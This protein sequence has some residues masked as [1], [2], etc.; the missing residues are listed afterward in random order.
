[1]KNI[2]KQ[3]ALVLSLVLMISLVSVT[4]ATAQNT[5]TLSHDGFTLDF[6]V[7]SSSRDSYTARLRITNNTGQGLYQWVLNLNRDMGLRSNDTVSG[8]RL[9][10]QQDGVTTISYDNWTTYIAAIPPRGS[11]TL[12]FNNA[13]TVDG[14]VPIPTD[15]RINQATKQ[16]LPEQYFSYSLSGSTW[17]NGFSHSLVID[18]KTGD[19][20]IGWEL[21]FDISGGA[22]ATV[23]NGVLLPSSTT[24][25]A[26]IVHPRYNPVLHPGSTTL[27]IGGSGDGSAISISNVR[28]FHMVAEPYLN[29]LAD[30]PPIDEPI[31]EPGDEPCDELCDEP[32]DEPEDELCCDEYPYCDDTDLPPV[33][34]PWVPQDPTLTI[35]SNGLTYQETANILLNDMAFAKNQ[36]RPVQAGT[37]VTLL[38]SLP[39]SYTLVSADSSMVMLSVEELGYGSAD[40][41]NLYRIVFA[42]PTNNT[43]INLEFEA[44]PEE[45]EPERITLHTEFEQIPARGLNNILIPTIDN[46]TVEVLDA[47][48]GVYQITI[49][50]DDVTV[51]HRAT[52]FFFWQSMYGTFEN[53]IDYRED[54]ATFVFRANPGTGGRNISLIMGVGDGLGQVARRAVMLRGNNAPVAAAAAQV[55]TSQLPFFFYNNNIFAPLSN[56]MIAD[57][58][59]NHW[60]HVAIYNL[61]RH[62]AVTTFPDG[63]FRPNDFITLERGLQLMFTT[64]EVPLI[65]PSEFGHWANRYVRYAAL[66]GLLVSNTN[67]LSNMT[68]EQVFF[69]LDFALNDQQNT[70]Y[71]NRFHS[72]PI[73]SAEMPFA[74]ADQISNARYRAAIQRMFEHGIIVGYNNGEL[75]PRELITRAELTALLFKAITPPGDLV[76]IRPP[77]FNP[78]LPTA[79]YE[80]VADTLSDPHFVNTLLF[81]FS[82]VMF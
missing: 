81:I 51:D 54:Y 77:A 59:S 17:H 30:E 82:T 21:N 29:F 11:L 46:V 44:V 9:E 24:G 75:R 58:P 56:L 47:L 57:V 27:T 19:R 6:E 78:P 39:V 71:W 14:V 66:N 16:P 36:A 22:L 80:G 13:R 15:F 12:Y 64:T 60:A 34:W 70:L 7:L 43:Q 1:M 4:T 40:Y 37:E 79:A 76:S 28:L 67:T 72:P 2:K 45:P 52:P 48:R 61:V 23:S 35:T 20:I 53:V 3:I 38:V 31:D 50:T 8:G 26:V 68:R 69:I 25:S 73:T 42:M 5:H 62:G 74:D 18:N 63:T 10:H 55:A 49:S 41:Y 32:C 33:N 65:P